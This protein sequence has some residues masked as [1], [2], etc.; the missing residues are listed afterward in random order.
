MPVFFYFQIG[1]IYRLW[2]TTVQFVQQQAKR[3][4][5]SYYNFVEFLWR[6]NFLQYI[7][8]YDPQF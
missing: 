5:I 6:L 4:Y 8:V 1:E 7:I 3:K 2:K